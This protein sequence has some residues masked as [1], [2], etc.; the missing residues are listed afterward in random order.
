MRVSQ[1]IDYA[2]RA[3]AL[4]ATRPE[5]TQV[6]AGDLADRLLLPRRFV[7]Q[8]ITALAR[9]GIVECRRGVG[10]GC[11]LARPAGDVTAL[12]IVRALE[13]GAVDIPR[14]EDSSAA[15]LW[16]GLAESVDGYLAS[17]TLE[18]LAD[19]QREI[20]ARLEPVYYI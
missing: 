3:L 12:E 7:E 10:G 9:T 17:V 18:D 2:L 1:R 20:D 15:A 8:Q 13:G 19:A 11:V 4:L 14:Q 5:G 16:Q 6:A